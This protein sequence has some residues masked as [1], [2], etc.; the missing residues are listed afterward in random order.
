M[1]T[2]VPEWWKRE[3]TIVPHYFN[4]LFNDF[5]LACETT[6]SIFFYWWVHSDVEAGVLL[7]RTI[8]VSLV[9]VAVVC[10]I[11]FSL[12]SWGRD[13]WCSAA[14]LFL[15]LWSCDYSLQLQFYPCRS[16][17]Q[18]RNAVGLPF[19]YT[20]LLSDNLNIWCYVPAHLEWLLTAGFWRCIF[21]LQFI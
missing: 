13:I 3:S 2:E 17:D 21:A 11:V 6:W 18:L 14:V 16:C 19:V 1:R 9:T 7:L 5:L 20:R 4:S 10:V 8:K 15:K 12:V